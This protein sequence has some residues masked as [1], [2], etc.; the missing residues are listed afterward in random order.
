MNTEDNKLRSAEG[1]ISELSGAE[2]AQSETADE[3]AGTLHNPWERSQHRASALHA[4]MDTLGKHAKP[5][6]VLEVARD[7]L[8][9]IEG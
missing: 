7:Y 8:A 1:L 2:E 5:E 3:S 9:F 4:A 6:K